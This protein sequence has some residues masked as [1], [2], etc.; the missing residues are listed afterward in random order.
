MSRPSATRKNILD[1]GVFR[2]VLTGGDGGSP[3]SPSQSGAMTLGTLCRRKQK[4][5]QKS[6]VKV[7][8]P[9]RTCDFFRSDNPPTRY[10]A[11]QQ[12][13]KYVVRSQRNPVSKQVEGLPE[14]PGPMGACDR[15]GE[16]APAR[17]GAGGTAGARKEQDDTGRRS[18]RPRLFVYV[19][20]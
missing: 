18:R 3:N 1:A 9:L 13:S 10:P 7:R 20:S 11:I 2:R 12:S 14:N 16:E 6:K 17:A 5:K 4:R 8:E 19:L 15:L